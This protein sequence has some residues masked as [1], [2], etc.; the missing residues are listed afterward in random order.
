MAVIA[1]APNHHGPAEVLPTW[2]SG[3]PGCSPTADA[4][5][6]AGLG[7]ADRP[8]ADPGAAGQFDTVIRKTGWSPA[9]AWSSASEDF[10]VTP[11]KKRLTSQPHFSR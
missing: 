5:A 6:T 8:R 3:R 1:L 11:W 7:A 4:T 9:A 2:A 10:A